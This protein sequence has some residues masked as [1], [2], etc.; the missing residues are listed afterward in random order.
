MEENPPFS[1]SVGERTVMNHFV[2]IH[3]G[4]Q[5]QREEAL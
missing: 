1:T 4:S 2:V 5:E 3:G